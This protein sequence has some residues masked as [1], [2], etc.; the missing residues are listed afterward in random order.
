M[1][2]QGAGHVRIFLMGD[3]S[4][5]DQPLCFGFGVMSKARRWGYGRL[6]KGIN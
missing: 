1:D 3:I 2:G 5:G 4:F 6:F